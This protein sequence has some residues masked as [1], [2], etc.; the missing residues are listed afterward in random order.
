MAH[1]VFLKV[2]SDITSGR[3]KAEEDMRLANRHVTNYIAE[4]LRNNKV[5]LLRQLNWVEQILILLQYK[6]TTQS[7]QRSMTPINTLIEAFQR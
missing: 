4:N 3:I 7:P 1:G 5:I 2:K 6:F